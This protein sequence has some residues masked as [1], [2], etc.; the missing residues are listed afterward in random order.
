MSIALWSFIILVV[1]FLAGIS[2]LKRTTNVDRTNADYQRRILDFWEGQAP[3]KIHGKIKYAD[4]KLVRYLMGNEN[5]E[6]VPYL[7]D[8]SAQDSFVHPA[9]IICPGGSYTFRSE[10]VEGIEIAQWLNSIGI[11]AFVLNYRVEPYK[12]PVPLADLTRAIQ[13]LRAHAT[14][15][16][17]DPERIGVLGSSA[18]AHLATTLGVHFGSVEDATNNMVTEE[19]CRPAV[20]ILSQPVVT[21]EEYDCQTDVEKRS[22]KKLLGENPPAS[23]LAFLSNEKHVTRETPPSFIWATKTDPMV[24]PKNAQ[25]FADA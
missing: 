14:K 23:M 3:Q 17:I 7:L 1:L 16:R 20:L 13:Y 18:G 12:H 15:Y 11:S 9:M 5:E 21:L 8:Y 2:L 10:K 24:N 4:M 19:N 25:L 22:I 6:R